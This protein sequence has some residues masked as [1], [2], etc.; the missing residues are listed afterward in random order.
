MLLKTWHGEFRGCKCFHTVNMLYSGHAVRGVNAERHPSHSKRG[1]S[2][3]KIFVS[4]S[5]FLS[6]AF[7]CLFGT[8]ILKKSPD[9]MQCKIEFEVLYK[10]FM[11]F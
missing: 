9:T 1:C 2:E 8:H 5:H 11:G 10:A 6:G 4:N 7:D 3:L